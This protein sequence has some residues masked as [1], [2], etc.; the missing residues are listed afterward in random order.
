MD[1]KRDEKKAVLYLVAQML[2]CF[3]LCQYGLQRIFGFSLF[4]DEFGY[5]A[6]AAKLLGWDWSETVSLGSYYSFGYSLILT[7][8]LSF[9]KD[10]IAAYRAAVVIN[11][12]LMCVSLGLMNRLIRKLLPDMEGSVAALVSGIAV[13]YPAWIF[14]VQMTMTEALLL[15]V[16]LLI[17]NLFFHFFEKPGVFTVIALAA[18]LIY[19]YLVHMRGIGTLAAGGAVFALE[20]WRNQNRGAQKKILAALVLMACLFA[21][22][23]GMKNLLIDGLYQ[24]ADAGT[25]MVN[26]YSGQW[27]KLRLLCSARGVRLL[28]LGLAGKL[29]YLGV[30]TFGLAW[31]GLWYAGKRAWKSLREK[32]ANPI[33]IFLFL[34]SAAQLGV[35]VIYTLRS[36]E[37]GNDRL[38]LFVHGRYCELIVPL[39]IALGIRQMLDSGRLWRQTGLMAAGMTLFTYLA[40][41]LAS[42]LELDNIH[43]YFMIGMSYLLDEEKVEPALF[44]WKALGLGILLMVLV[45]ALIDIYRKKFPSLE[46]V[47]LPLLALQVA[48]GIQASEHY[49]YIGNSYGYMDIQVADKLKAVLEEEGQEGR[50][51]IIHLYE[52]G[53]PYIEQIQFRLRDAQ[54]EIWNVQGIG[55]DG[56]RIDPASCEAQIET[57]LDRLK[58][59][60]KVI[61]GAESDWNGRLEELYGQDW[62]SGH[63]CLYYNRDA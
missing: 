54:I 40:S 26:D 52:G 1:L 51:R 33:W 7:P 5:W 25:L 59:E 14:Y 19:I 49:V 62:K 31:R 60:D 46:W 24:R 3:C 18:A 4:P 9:V 58:P 41:G 48:L 61:S 37:E 27:E 12:L 45:S 42:R 57:V 32:D 36:A 34:A 13:L 11:M 63:L 50:G 53:T 22:G 44:L 29:L 16:Y 30:S 21:V 56:E 28:G 8:I 38:D 35:T 10:S 23:L 15:F 17:C 55:S 6:P 47:L 39:L 20:C 2:L 43:G